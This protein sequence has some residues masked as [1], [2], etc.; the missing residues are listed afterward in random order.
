MAE[1]YT[2][3]RGGQ[4]GGRGRGRG[5]RCERDRRPG[6]QYCESPTSN[7]SQADLHHRGGVR[8]GRGV[9]QSSDRSPQSSRGRELHSKRPQYSQRTLEVA[10][11]VST[12]STNSSKHIAEDPQPTSLPLPCAK[13]SVNPTAVI[14]IGTIGRKIMLRANLFTVNISDDLGYIH[15][16][17]AQIIPKAPR[18]VNVAVIDKMVNDNPAIFV[19]QKVAYDGQKNLY[20]RKPLNGIS[21][22]N[23][24]YML[25]YLVLC[26]MYLPQ[27]CIVVT[28]GKN[29][30]F[31]FTPRRNKSKKV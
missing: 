23:E 29:Y 6:H 25:I 22:Q 26:E 1:R 12:S 3:T 31:N 21:A 11:S 8:G 27:Y 4:R 9:H 20:V 15:H 24:V 5:N 7:R 2:N 13:P 17:D 18:K 28:L 19:R 16:Y 10:D 30:S 14:P